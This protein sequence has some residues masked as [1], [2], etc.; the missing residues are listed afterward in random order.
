MIYCIVITKFRS[1][2]TLLKVLL[3]A[4]LLTG[5]TLVAQPPFL[6][7]QP[8]EKEDIPNDDA[9]EEDEDANGGS[10]ALGVA[11]SV[12]AGASGGLTY[13]SAKRCEECPKSLLMISAGICSILIALVCPLMDIKNR[14]FT[15]MS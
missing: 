9:K 14:I 15:G 8:E 13:V 12:L 2:V 10:Y 11:I 1:P 5:V 4:T 3:C 6:L 7:G